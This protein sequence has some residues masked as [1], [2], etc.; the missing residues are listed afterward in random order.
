MIE[1]EIFD[2]TRTLS[3]ER[4][5]E[6]ILR[7]LCA[8]ASAELRQRLKAG[9]SVEEIHSA[10][11]TATGLLALSMAML[12]DGEGG[13]TGF[14]AGSLSLRFGEQPLSAGRLRQQ[15]EAL[16]RGYLDDE[17]FAFVGVPG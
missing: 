3:G 1:E 9:V 7:A 10:F 8:A 14:Q 17:G 2:F 13:L 12:A 11:V 6:E 16:L 15:A 5:P 4:T